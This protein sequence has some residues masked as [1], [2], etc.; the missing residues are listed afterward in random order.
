MS[1]YSGPEGCE[2][3]GAHYHAI[4]MVTQIME[5][6]EYQSWPEIS[7]L[8]A[9]YSFFV[10]ALIYLFMPADLPT[11]SSMSQSAE[12]RKKKQTTSEP[13]LVENVLSE[14]LLWV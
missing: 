4:E 2:V 7:N 6:T 12:E 1:K 5:L 11:T 9:I 3:R 13:W 14:L 8:H 10:V